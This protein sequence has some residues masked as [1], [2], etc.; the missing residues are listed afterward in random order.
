MIV[1][2]TLGAPNR[3]CQSCKRRKVKCD[4]RTPSCQACVKSKLRCYYTSY[5][6][7]AYVEPAPVQDEDENVRHLRER[8]EAVEEI[9]RQRWDRIQKLAA[10][11]KALQAA[12]VGKKGGKNKQR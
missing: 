5:S 10:E 4:R 2:N 11:L 6:P 8:L 1:G 9:G 7:P 3:S 12:K